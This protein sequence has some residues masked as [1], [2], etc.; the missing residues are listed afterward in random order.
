MNIIWNNITIEMNDTDK[1]CY[2]ARLEEIEIKMSNERD[3]LN[4]LCNKYHE[5][6]KIFDEIHKNLYKEKY[7]IICKLRQNDFY[8]EFC[9][10]NKTIWVYN[11]YD[12]NI[13]FP[14]VIDELI[15][16]N[17]LLFIENSNMDNVKICDDPVSGP[18]I[19][20]NIDNTIYLEYDNEYDYA[21]INKSNLMEILNELIKL[22]K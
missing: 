1:K 19:I 9:V 8:I 6:I 15:F 11:R 20:H 12:R 4:G 17:I 2:E 10:D 16:D 7:E 3:K 5:G 18:V 22:K 21:L 14:L 13:I